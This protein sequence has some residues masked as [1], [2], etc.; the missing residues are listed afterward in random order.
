MKQI[1]LIS[2]FPLFAILLAT[3]TLTACDSD[4]GPTGVG[5]GEAGVEIRGTV[6]DEAGFGKRAG[7]IEGAVVTTGRVSSTGNVT[8]LAG[9]TTTQADGSFDLRVETDADLLVVFAEKGTFS[10]QTLVYL[11]E[12]EPSSVQAMP[13]TQETKAEAEVYL[14][15]Q[16]SSRTSSTTMADVALYVDADVAASIKAGQT[17]AAEV[18]LAIGDANAAEERYVCDAEGDDDQACERPQQA[19]REEEKGFLTLQ[20]ALANASSVSAEQAS[21]TTFAETMAE[22]YSTVG[23]SLETEARAKAV[24]QTSLNQGTA[25]FS[26]ETRFALNKRA[27]LAASHATAHAL[28]AAFAAEGASQT[29]MN[30]LA[31]A[32][33]EW[34]TALQAATTESSM[35]SAEAT[36]EA[37]VEA[38]L[39]AELGVVQALLATAKTSVAVAK[40]ALDASLTTASSAEARAAAHATFFASAET[41]ARTALATSAKADLGG[42]VLALL[43]VN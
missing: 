34:M 18:A 32:R 20:A 8:M 21:L 31:S 12:D 3:L 28:E 9:E 6:T 36:Y 2:R 4:D 14:A 15:T 19:A 7:T 40:G 30:A 25:T 33:T 26:T 13:M 17:S 11:G 1:P 29:Q 35:E 41:A 16:G 10:S 43:S 27:A 5:T 42:R 24:A 22:A 38:A 37:R 23:A 39:Q